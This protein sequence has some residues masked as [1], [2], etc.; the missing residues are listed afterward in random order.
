MMYKLW[1]KRPQIKSTSSKF[2]K[3]VKIWQTYC[4]IGQCSKVKFFDKVRSL[5]E[6]KVGISPAVFCEFKLGSLE[7]LMAFQFFNEEKAYASSNMILTMVNIWNV[8]NNVKQWYEILSKVLLKQKNLKIV[9][10]M[11]VWIYD[12]II[13]NKHYRMI[14]SNN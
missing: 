7:W 10:K 8:I 13:F 14:F 4:G 9:W 5:W 6:E 1:D 12:I 11:S 3:K 2:K